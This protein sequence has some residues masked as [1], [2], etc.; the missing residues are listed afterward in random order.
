MKS[1]RNFSHH[2]FVV[3]FE[4]LIDEKGSKVSNF[5]AINFNLNKLYYL[6][7]FT[8]ILFVLSFGLIF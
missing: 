2:I 4:H 8:F 3:R 6:T 5:Y 7:I 1:E